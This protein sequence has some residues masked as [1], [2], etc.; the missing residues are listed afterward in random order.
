MIGSTAGTHPCCTTWDTLRRVGSDQDDQE[1]TA[2]QL[3]A[4]IGRFVR[5]T[6]EREGPVPPSRLETLGRLHRT[7][8]QTMAE[9]AEA[10]GVSHQSVSRMVADL[11]RQA[12]V[13]RTPHPLD[14]RGY[15]IE[16]TEAG[17]R[18]LVAQRRARAALIADAIRETLTKRDQQILARV[19]A[20]LD[21]LS[22][23]LA[24]AGDAR[25]AR[26]P[27]DD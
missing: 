22:E 3:R 14:A 7:G 18:A 10:R 1:T 4:A 16:L 27:A 24:A 17:H 25:G 21:Q 9:L 8:P 23:G 2:E 26:R 5:A 20:L 12:L 19:P 6:K 15:L 13:T 11:E